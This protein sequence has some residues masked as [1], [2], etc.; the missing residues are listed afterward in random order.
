[1]VN[2]N[3]NDKTPIAAAALD[4]TRLDV[5]EAVGGLKVNMT[6]LYQGSRS[7]Q[8]LPDGRVLIGSHSGPQKPLSL[9]DDSDALNVRMTSMET[10]MAVQVG[11]FNAHV[12]TGGV[13]PGGLTGTIST[14]A[15]TP[16]STSA[17]VTGTAHIREVQ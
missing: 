14:P 12:H 4:W 10:Q 9:K 5:I 17:T 13:L 6:I 16:V 2:A 3:S 11:L 15:Q 8:L 7:V 1:M